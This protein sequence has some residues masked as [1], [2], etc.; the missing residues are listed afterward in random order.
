MP[1]SA[2][3]KTV[4]HQLHSHI[5]NGFV[6]DNTQRVHACS[7]L[8]LCICYDLHLLCLLVQQL[9][10]LVSEINCFGRSAG[11]CQAHRFL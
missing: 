11:E 9:K 7:F 10:G 5:Q 1:D 6:V 2:I 3:S 4:V 8:M